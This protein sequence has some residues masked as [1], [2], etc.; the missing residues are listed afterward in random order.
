MVREYL[1]FVRKTKS[2][3]NLWSVEIKDLSG[4]IKTFTPNIDISA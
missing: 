2:E 3:N 1:G 4:E